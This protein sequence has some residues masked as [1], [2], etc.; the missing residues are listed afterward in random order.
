MKT[1]A[2]LLLVIV[3]VFSFSSFG[4]QSASAPTAIENA[5]LILD[6]TP[7]DNLVIV[8]YYVEET[9]NMTFGK[10]ITK[11]E[12]SKLSMVNT[13]DL[14]PHNTRTVTPIYR[15]AKVKAVEE[16]L[17]PKT[18]SDNV[19]TAIKPVKVE[20]I[21]PSEPQKYIN[22]DVVATYEKVLDKGYKTTEMLT[23]V[24]DK[25]Y[26]SGDLATAVKYYSQLFEM[27]TNL[28][29][30]YYYRYAQCLKGMDQIEKANEMMKLF[31]IKNSTSKVARK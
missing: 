10:R 5:T 1:Y 25:A 19:S 8:A 13:Y 9:I 17:Q 21:A 3:P 12:V 29:A 23:R 27:N 31:E 20:V 18:I 15:K 26:F 4:Q 24:A 2:T 22:I 28:E 14:G 16:N 6:N 30:M 7:K 11:Y